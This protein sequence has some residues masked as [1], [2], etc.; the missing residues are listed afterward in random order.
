M[1]ENHT[2]TPPVAEDEAAPYLGFTKHALR[3]WR[4]Q[5]KGPHLSAWAAASAIAS[6]ISTDS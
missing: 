6:R 5:G 2:P 4:S 1:D 3:A